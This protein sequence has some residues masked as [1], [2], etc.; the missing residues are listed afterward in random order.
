MEK[1][2]TKE[3]LEELCM[4]QHNAERMKESI[5]TH[6]RAIDKMLL[7]KTVRVSFEAAGYCS[8]TYTIDADLL[9]E[10]FRKQTTRWRDQIDKIEK[11]IENA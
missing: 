6:E 10:A 8:S 11:E 2:M 1:K 5:E 4:K 7:A 9:A 3:K